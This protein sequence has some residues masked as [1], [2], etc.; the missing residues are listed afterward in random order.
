METQSTPHVIDFE[1]EYYIHKIAEILQKYDAYFCE[2]L[3]DE[4]EVDLP[5]Y[6]KP[7]SPETEA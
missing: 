7:I 3:L 2:C 5:K 6:Y 4:I 1:R